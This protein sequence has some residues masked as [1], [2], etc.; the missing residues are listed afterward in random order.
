MWYENFAAAASVCVA[1]NCSVIDALTVQRV[2]AEACGV[3][4]RS[5]RNDFWG[6][7][8]VEVITLLCAL[9]RL[10]SRYADGIAYAWD[11]YIM[12]AILPVWLG[13]TLCGAIARFTAFGVDLYTISDPNTITSGLKLFYICE[14]FYFVTLG[15]CKMMVLSFYLRIFPNTKFRLAAYAIMLYVAIFTL[16]ALFLQIFQCFPVA[17]IWEGW[18]GDFGEYQCFDVNLMTVVVAANLIGQDVAILLLPL[19]LLLQLNIS[20]KKRG[21]IILLF[22]L[23]IFVVITSSIRLQ[24]IVIMAKSTNPT[25]DYTD[26]IIWTGLEVDISVIVACLPAIRSYLSGRIKFLASTKEGSG[27]PNDNCNSTK[28]TRTPRKTAQM[29][30]SSI[31][32]KRVME[33]DHESQIELGDKNMGFTQTEIGTA[34]IV[35]PDDRSIASM[36]DGIYVQKTTTMKTSGGSTW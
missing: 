25:Y 8:P 13:F 14:T 24:Y 21:S 15:L 16:V 34:S 32:P 35:T 23:G 33:T 22:S 11:D 5:R 7:F 3:P 4:V 9:M 29:H 28:A 10:Y 18:R 1:M 19:P 17:S 20:W 30:L 36:E 26:V 31:A 6:L 27:S 12:V 2:E